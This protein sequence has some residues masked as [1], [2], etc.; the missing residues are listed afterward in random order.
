MND[1]TRIITTPIPAS[2]SLFAGGQVN[3]L[4]SLADVKQELNITNTTDD[5]WMSKLIS[6][7]SSAIQ[8]YCNRQ[9][10]VS[11]WFDQVWP[12]AG[13]YVYQ[14]PPRLEPLQL[15]NWPI[16]T[17][18]SPS[19]TAPPL[20][21]TLSAVGGGSLAAT[22][23]YVR[24][25]YVT[26]SGETALSF[27]SFLAVPAN[28][29]LQIAAPGV[30]ELGIATGW[31]AYVATASFTET[32]QNLTL[33]GIGATWTLPPTGLVAGAAGPSYVS[34]VENGPTWATPLGEG[35]DFLT[36]AA[37]GQLT[38]LAQI[39]LRPKEWSL[40]IQV[41][42]PAGFATIPLDVQDAAI[43]LVKGRYY[44]RNR[45]PMVRQQDAQGLFSETYF[46]ATGPGG[47]GDLPVDVM[48]KLDRYRVPVTA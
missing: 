4:V 37:I 48:A 25:S 18:P 32:K 2:A 44:S 17:T 20:A 36:N 40:P 10:Q 7:A 28:N 6:R 15:A 14:L 43:L 46:F 24:I 31:N 11:T 27:E 41:I 12:Q 1:L 29:L 5:A 42:Y 47:Q 16:A 30:D 21:P 23:Y 33:T 13:P 26:P 8:N 22:T 38:R 39:T 19:G 34:V 3:D 45:D 9:F 35:V